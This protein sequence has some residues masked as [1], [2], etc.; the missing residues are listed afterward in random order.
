MINF[1]QSNSS[2]INFSIIDDDVWENLT[3]KILKKNKID[4]LISDTHNISIKYN[5]DKKN[6]IKDYLNYIIRNKSNLITSQF[7]DFIENI[8]HSQESNTQIFINYSL[9]KL[10]YFLCVK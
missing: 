2:N 3:D 6:I 9:S 5:I 1:M 7:L 4:V 10:S 8:M